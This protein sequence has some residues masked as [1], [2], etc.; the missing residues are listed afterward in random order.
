MFEGASISLA[1]L[2]PPPLLIGLAAL[3]ACWRSTAWRGGR[4]GRGL[5]ALAFAAILAAL[6][7]PSWV[8]ERREP[9]AD[10]AVI[11]DD[12]SASQRIDGREDETAAAV[13]ELEQKL[14][15]LPGTE[16]RVVQVT[17]AAAAD[18]SGEDEGTRLFSALERALADVPRRRIAGVI[19]VTDGQVHDAPESADALELAAPFHVLLTGRDDE[20]DRRLIVKE[21]PTYGIVGQKQSMVLHVDDMPAGSARPREGHRPARRE[22]PGLG[23]SGNR[24]GQRHRIRARSCRPDRLRDRGRGRDRASSPSPTTAPSSSST[25]CATGCACCWSPASR[26]RASAP[27]ATC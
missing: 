1:P 12:R 24:R 20:I 13:A 17:D 18:A 7:N 8:E 3:A 26:I 15:R 4:A 14:R 25:A 16:V 19:A 6:A 22:A 23:R 5:R 10:V 21:I 9:L 2:I 27:G 11:V